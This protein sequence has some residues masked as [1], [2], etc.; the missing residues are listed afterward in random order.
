MIFWGAA[1][2]EFVKVFPSGIISVGEISVTTEQMCAILVTGV[3]FIVLTLFF[4]YTRLG[5]AMRGT[6]EGHSTV[7]SMGISPET[8]IGASWAVASVVATIGGILLGSIIGFSVTLKEI[9]LV[10]IPAAFVGGLDSIL[11]AIIGGLVIG[12]VQ[13]LA[14]GYIGMASGTP[15]TFLVLILVMFLKPAGLFGLARI[16]RV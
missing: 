9:G 10:A 5:L 14:G 8:M 7:R 1:P 12:V 2:L 15:A 6:A 4:R 3:L 13:M 16:E 11:G